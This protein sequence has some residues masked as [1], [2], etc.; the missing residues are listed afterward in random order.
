MDIDYSLEKNTYSIH[1]NSVYSLL[2]IMQNADMNTF[3]FIVRQMALSGPY[4]FIT[5]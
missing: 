1:D 5:I 4:T 3:E 2:F